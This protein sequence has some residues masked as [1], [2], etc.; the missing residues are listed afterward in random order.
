[1]ALALAVAF[2]VI[3]VVIVK[4]GCSCRVRFVREGVWR[5]GFVFGLGRG[6]EGWW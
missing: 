5:V 4:G 3:V 2:A 1:M 6:G